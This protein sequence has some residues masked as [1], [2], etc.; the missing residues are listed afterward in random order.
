ML[1]RYLS[2]ESAF[3]P[4]RPTIDQSTLK[5]IGVYWRADTQFASLLEG[6]HQT[7]ELWRAAFGH[8]SALVLGK[9]VLGA[10]ES[11]AKSKLELITP[12]D[13]ERLDFSA[14][15][16]SVVPPGGARII[17]IET[18]RQLL[19]WCASTVP[20]VTPRFFI[21]ATNAPTSVWVRAGDHSLARFL[22][23]LSSK[24]AFTASATP[25]RIPCR[26][27]CSQQS[28]RSA[29]VSCGRLG[30]GSCVLTPL[31]RRLC[32]K[33]A[34]QPEFEMPKTLL[35]LSG[36]LDCSMFE[37]EYWANDVDSVPQPRFLPAPAR[38][39]RRLVTLDSSGASNFLNSVPEL[40]SFDHLRQSLWP[41]QPTP[42][43]LG[44]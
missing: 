15:S 29:A 44:R 33:P 37:F 25:G 6:R 31:K 11:I 35:A 34:S 1:L 22:R 20:A 26:E 7:E 8:L 3:S 4:D 9:E 40:Y 19:S 38:Y 41:I 39:A 28:R 23:K 18:R 43:L 13:L 21:G 14:L 42:L 24:P 5:H 30:R 12:H 27:R 2:H 32:F 17:Q 10:L 36:F 16:T